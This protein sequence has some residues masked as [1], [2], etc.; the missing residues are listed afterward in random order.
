MGPFIPRNG[1]DDD[2]RYLIE[3]MT[4][5][6]VGRYGLS[7]D[8]VEDIRQD[9]LLDLLKRLPHYNSQL[10]QRKTFIHRLI[11]HELADLLSARQAGCRDHRLR[12]DSL[13][14]P[15]CEEDGIML[16]LMDTLDERHVLR[17]QGRTR[18]SPEEV[19]ELR[20]DLERLLATLTPEQRQIC[21]QLIDHTVTEVARML[22]V[23]RTSI[24]DI[25]QKLRV[26]FNAAGLRDYL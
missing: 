4:R 9:L 8:D 19:T 1:I 12:T 18:R 22:A 11:E 7:Y 21:A 17:M 26:L 15:V 20:V 13:D 10:S 16:L 6:L 5:H 2:V 25:V 24:Q 3:V 14:D 23:P